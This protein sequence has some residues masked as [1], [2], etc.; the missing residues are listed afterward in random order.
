[1]PPLYTA[2]EID[3]ATWVAAYKL[4]RLKMSKSYNLPKRLAQQAMRECDNQLR[5]QHKKGI[6]DEG[7]PNHP[8]Y[9]G[10]FNYATGQYVQM[11]GYTQNALLSK[12]YR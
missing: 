12:Q 1:M 2:I 7:D 6:F 10:G 4:W 8:K 5:A 9:N 11:F 3:F